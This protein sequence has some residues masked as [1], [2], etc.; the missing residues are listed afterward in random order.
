MMTEGR[1]ETCSNNKVR[2]TIVFNVDS[3]VDGTINPSRWYNLVIRNNPGS[4]TSHN[5]VIFTL[6]E[7]ES[8]SSE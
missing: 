1:V 6:S 5:S 7:S 8:L 3:C 4:E 2:A